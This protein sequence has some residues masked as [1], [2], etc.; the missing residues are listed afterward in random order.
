MS[1]LILGLAVF[2]AIHLIPAKPALR[3][4]LIDRIGLLPYK[5]VF[6]LASIA[7]FIAIVHGKAGAP[8]VAVWNPPVQL[9]MV[10]KLLMLPAFIL[11][12]AAYIPSNIKR[13]I[14]H[15][16]L[17]GVKCWALAHLCINGDLASLLLF[18][19]FLAYGVIAMIS[20]NKRNKDWEPGPGKPIYMDI[21]VVVVGL[22]AYVGV[23][24]HHMQLFGVPI[25]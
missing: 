11:I 9:A 6:A 15:P 3:N 18:G 12:V 24:M 23:A 16:M 13:K 21:I 1:L 14:R 7:G 4:A 8:F 5:G 25:F 2:F 17:A 10:T 22:I 19:S 20:A